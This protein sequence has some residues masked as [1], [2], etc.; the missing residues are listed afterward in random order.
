M[1]TLRKE[2]GSLANL[3]AGTPL[4]AQLGMGDDSAKF[5]EWVDFSLLPPF[6]QISKYFYISVFSGSVTPE[7]FL[8]KVYSPAPPRMKQ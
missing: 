8:L 7:G 4:S 5:K 1:E 3:F 6:D 2:S